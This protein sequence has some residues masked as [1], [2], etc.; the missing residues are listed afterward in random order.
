MTLIPWKKGKAIVWDFTCT[1]TYASTNLPFSSI[2]AGLVA[3]RREAEKRKKYSN[4]LDKY[5]FATVA[6]E[7]SGSWG[8]EGLNFIKEVGHHITTRTG[9]PRATTFLIQRI[10]IAVQRGN[11]AAILG[12]LPQGKELEEVFLL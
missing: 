11:V 2:R 12:T 10:S 9:D 4:L 5:C 7:T 1:D 6:I 8:S 3:T